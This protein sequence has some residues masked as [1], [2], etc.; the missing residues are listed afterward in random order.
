MRA[1]RGL[2]FALATGLILPACGSDPANVAGEYSLA[3][4]SREN[5][6][7]LEN[8]VEGTTASNIPL[9]ITQDGSNATAIVSGPV[10]AA[11]LDLWLGSH[12]FQGKV[13]ESRV[14]LTLWGVTSFHEGNC[15]YTLNCT[16]DAGLN[17]DL[18]TGNILYQAATNDNPDCG[19]LEGC[20]SRQEF[21]ATRPPT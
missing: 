10:W 15:T 19:S 8:W 14:R 4:T 2:V 17:G 11:F 16:L 13:S 9:T 20:T 21:N 5:G 6:C 7:N 1:I 3:L 12:T 18:L